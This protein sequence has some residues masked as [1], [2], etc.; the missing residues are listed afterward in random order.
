[1]DHR[2]KPEKEED[3]ERWKASKGTKVMSLDWVP[4]E[5]FSNF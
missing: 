4:Q 3:A 5:K 2:E 1:M